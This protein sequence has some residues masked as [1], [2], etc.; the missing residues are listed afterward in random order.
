MMRPDEKVIKAFAIT[1]RQFPELLE[2]LDQWRM[3]E[4]EQLPQAINH[5]AVLQGRCQV[6]NELYK[7]AEQAP[8]QA[9]K[10]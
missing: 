8:D 3:K 1:V 5:V 7:F 10:S 6:L 4:L 9:A 2:F